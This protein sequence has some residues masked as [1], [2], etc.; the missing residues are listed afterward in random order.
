MLTK[1]CGQGL[2]Y[3]PADT[4][5]VARWIRQAQLKSRT[6]E[7]D[8]IEVDYSLGDIQ[9]IWHLLLPD[10]P[11]LADTLSAYTEGQDAVRAVMVE[12][13][14]SVEDE[15]HHVLADI[16][17]GMALQ[18]VV[19][20]YG[21][22][23]LQDEERV[24]REMGLLIE[25]MSDQKIAGIA[26]CREVFAEDP[27]NHSHMKWFFR[28]LV[29]RY[30]DAIEQED[31]PFEDYAKFFPWLTISVGEPYYLAAAQCLPPCDLRML[32][33]YLFQES[34]QGLLLSPKV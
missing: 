28:D 21:Y 19:E 3:N 22:D 34:E 17:A 24:P 13:P 7:F 33:K 29:G 32:S 30:K 5:V 31:A 25:G 23:Y 9:F 27:E 2:Y 1:R 15:E 26:H 16:F 4:Q 6:P 18:G 11:K 10:N 8:L 20:R 14:K 12:L